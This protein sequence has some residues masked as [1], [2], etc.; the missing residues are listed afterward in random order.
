MPL[1]RRLPP[2]SAFA[3]VLCLR[4]RPSCHPELSCALL[5]AP[6]PP[7]WPRSRLQRG[8]A[9]ESGG[10]AAGSQGEPTKVA[11]LI[12]DVYPGLDDPALND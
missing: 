4:P 5:S 7:A 11:R 2:S 1:H 10:A 8:F 3:P 12:S 9:A 6:G